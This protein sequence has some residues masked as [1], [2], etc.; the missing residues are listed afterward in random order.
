MSRRATAGAVTF[1]T[2]FV[3]PA[4][5]AQQLEPKTYANLPVGLNFLVLGYGH[6]Q[7]GLSTDPSLPLDDAHLNI[8]TGIVAYARSLDLWGQSGK[9]DLSL[10]YSKLAGS[11]VVAGTPSE[12]HVAGFGDPRVRLSLNLYGAPSLPLA[13]FAGFRPDLVIGT[14]IQI[15]APG[16]QY[17]PS[18]LVNLGTNR[19]S[20]KPDLGLSKAFGPLTLD[21]TAGVTFQSKNDDY[22]GGHVQQQAPIYSFQSNISYNFS[23]GIWAAFGVTYYRGG[24]TTVDDAQKHDDLS[25]SRAGLTLSVPIDR[26]QSVKL[27]AS[28]GIST[29]TGTN[30]NTASVAWQ[31]GW[32]TGL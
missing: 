26:H 11:A 18:K 9:L 3:A 20:V 22:F 19:W 14:S 32:G 8:D 4:I 2:I 5:Q 12:R 29:R 10:P 24:R 31:Y 21:L 25:N 15:T 30:F 28:T 23:R 27:N 1:A 17:D 7:G 16:A 13:L 6:S